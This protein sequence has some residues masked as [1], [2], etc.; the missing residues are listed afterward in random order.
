MTLR[1][2]ADRS[3]KQCS[4]CG[5]MKPLAD[6]FKT[7]RERLRGDCKPCVAIK[8]RAYN[9]NH[10]HKR[11]P[12]TE[13][14]RV[15]MARWRAK[16]GDAYRRYQREYHAIWDKAKRAKQRATAGALTPPEGVPT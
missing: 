8:A 13:H 3:M 6:Y 10:K 11:R 4:M 14:D 1:Y 5:V 15:A 12:Y 9:A 16:H 2:N 7:G